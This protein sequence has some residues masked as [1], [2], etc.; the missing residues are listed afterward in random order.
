MEHA[1]VRSGITEGAAIRAA[2]EDDRHLMQCLRELWAA[3][4]SIAPLPD[5]GFVRQNSFCWDPVFIRTKVPAE[6]ILRAVAAL[7]EIQSNQE[8]SPDAV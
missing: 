6:A 5:G 1:D 2:C 3:G 4:Y 8:V 7:W